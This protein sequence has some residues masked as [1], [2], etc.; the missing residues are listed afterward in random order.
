MEIYE[1][2]IIYEKR[3]VDCKSFSVKNKHDLYKFCKLIINP[4][5][6]AEYIIVIG[7]DSNYVPRSY[8]IIG[9]GVEDEV[10]FTFS[11]IMRYVILSGCDKFVMIHNHR[12]NCCEISADDVKTYRNLNKLAAKFDIEFIDDYVITNS[13]LIST[14]AM[15]LASK[16]RGN[17][18]KAGR[19]KKKV[20][21]IKILN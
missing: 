7:V 20:N 3:Q 15:I 2:K 16:K 17:K 9:G 5:S 6:V 4:D 14:K 11:T 19:I 13:G 10:T 12:C 1:S 8:Y 21:N 18:K